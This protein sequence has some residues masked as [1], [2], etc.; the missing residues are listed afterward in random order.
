MEICIEFLLDWSRNV[1]STDQNAL[2]SFSKV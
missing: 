2:M 1:E